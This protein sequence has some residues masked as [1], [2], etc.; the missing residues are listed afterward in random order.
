MSYMTMNNRK[1]HWTMELSFYTW[2][3][4]SPRQHNNHTT[5]KGYKFKTKNKKKKNTNRTGIVTPHQITANLRQFKVQ[6]GPPNQ[7]TIFSTPK[8][9]AV[10]FEHLPHQQLWKNVAKRL[11]MAGLCCLLE[12]QDGMVWIYLR[13]SMESILSS[14]LKVNG[15]KRVPSPS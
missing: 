4:K 15:W 5:Q 6:L 1:K 9:T 11:L 7:L 14:S 2:K 3:L 12:K 10:C 13:S 8:W